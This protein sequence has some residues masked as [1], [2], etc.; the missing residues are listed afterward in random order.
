MLTAKPG[1]TRSPRLF[2]Q[3]LKPKQSD[4]SPAGSS[5]ARRGLAHPPPVPCLL[6]PRATRGLARPLPPRFP[7]HGQP[8]SRTR[9]VTIAARE[10]LALGKE[11]FVT[12]ETVPNTR[13]AQVPGPRRSTS[14][15]Y[16]ESTR[17]TRKTYPSGPPPGTLRRAP[18]LSGC[19]HLLSTKTGFTS[20]KRRAGGA[21]LPP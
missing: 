19:H 9:H 6:D 14:A 4:L 8:K 17:P 11:S 21:S 15:G 18:E 12:T 2:L 13:Q 10:K 1:D 7:F 20:S 16:L 3:R 5:P